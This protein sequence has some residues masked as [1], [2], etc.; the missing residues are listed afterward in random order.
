M[1]KLLV[2]LFFII[3]F[4]PNASAQDHPHSFSIGSLYKPTT[5]Q[6]GFNIQWMYHADNG[7]YLFPEFEYLFSTKASKEDT[8]GSLAEVHINW[9][10]G[11][12]FEI[13]DGNAFIF[14]YF[15]F[16]T[17]VTLDTIEIE[18]TGSIYSDNTFILSPSIG[19]VTR[20]HLGKNFFLSPQLRYTVPLNAKYNTYISAAIGFGIFY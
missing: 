11:Y 19:A 20:I 10:T 14:P 3:A 1:K 5:S 13:L 17:T 12:E 8:Q 7:F 9:I 4:Y 2:F 16:G 18:S 15:G 6:W